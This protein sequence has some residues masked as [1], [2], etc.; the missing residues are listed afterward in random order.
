[1]A[2]GP[3]LRQEIVRHV[4]EGNIHIVIDLQNVDFIDSTSLG[5]LLG[6]VKEREAMVVILGVQDYRAAFR[7][8]FSLTGLDSVLS[9]VDLN[10]DPST[11][12]PLK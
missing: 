4:S 12:E 9:S 11:W 3:Q 5:I 1:M 2:T 8:F 6:G 10:Q 7:K